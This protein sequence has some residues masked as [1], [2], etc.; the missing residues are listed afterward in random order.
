[1][2]M[3]NLNLDNI[4]YVLQAI[5]RRMLFSLLS[6]ERQDAISNRIKNAKPECLENKKCVNCGCKVPLMLYSDKPCECLILNQQ[7]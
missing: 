2:T 6:I 5:G 1:M 7:K 4:G 3:K